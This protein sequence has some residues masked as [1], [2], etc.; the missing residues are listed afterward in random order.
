MK[1]KQT[2]EESCWWKKSKKKNNQKWTKLK[3]DK[4]KNTN[5][6]KGDFILFDL[7]WFDSCVGEKNVNGVG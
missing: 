2:M 5:E 1:Q 4:N 6:S 3:G 7:I